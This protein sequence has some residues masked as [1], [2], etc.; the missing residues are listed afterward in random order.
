[1]SRADHENLD[2]TFA[3]TIILVVFVVL[4][5]LYVLSPTQEQTDFTYDNVPTMSFSS[6]G[7]A[8]L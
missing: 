1:M 8:P 7:G 3:T 2:K 6:V 5:R 4:F